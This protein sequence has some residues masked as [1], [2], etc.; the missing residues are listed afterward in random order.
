M[1]FY[2]NEYSSEESSD[3]ESEINYNIK[4]LSNNIHLYITTY[5]EEKKWF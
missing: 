5:G 4:Y 1:I 3:S 2:I